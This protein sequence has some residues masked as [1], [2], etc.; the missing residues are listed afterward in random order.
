MFE[1]EPGNISAHLGV[2]NVLLQKKEHTQAVS[3]IN[4]LLEKEPKK[5]SVAVEYAKLCHLTNRCDKAVVHLEALMNELRLTPQDETLA[6]FELGRLY[7][8][9]KDYEKAFKGT[10]KNTPFQVELA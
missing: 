2:I 6:C 9:G 10:S 3:V 5:L 7:D 1:I 4:G 8:A